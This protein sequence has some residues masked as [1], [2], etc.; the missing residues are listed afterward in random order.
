MTLEQLTQFDGKDD[1][2]AYFAYQGD[3][4][5]ATGSPLWKNGKHMGRHQAG[6]DLTE[7]LSQAPHGEDKVKELKK[8]GTLIVEENQKMSPPQKVFYTMAYL[9]LSFVLLI[10]LV[11]ACWRWW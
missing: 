7:V 9:N 1:R 10:I 6:C 8:V 4:Y 5:D 3:I 2:K 11:L